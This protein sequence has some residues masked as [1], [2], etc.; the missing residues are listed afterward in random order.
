M[1]FISRGNLS[2]SQ[3]MLTRVSLSCQLQG[4]RQ[5]RTGTAADAGTTAS[6]PTRNTPE[7]RA[8]AEP[9]EF[10]RLRGSALL[11]KPI[12][13][14][15]THPT[16]ALQAN[17]EP[18]KP[19]LDSTKDASRKGHASRPTSSLRRTCDQ[20]L[21]H[22]TARKKLL[23]TPWKTPQGHNEAAEAERALT[24]DHGLHL[25]LQHN[26]HREHE[27]RHY[28]NDY[29]RKTQ[30]HSPARTYISGGNLSSGPNARKVDR[31]QDHESKESTPEPKPTRAPASGLPSTSGERCR[32][33][34]QATK[35]L[36]DAPYVD[37]TYASGTTVRSACNTS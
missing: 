18:S 7:F 28:R 27:P 2:S 16:H 3:L 17:V 34:T 31:D 15:G 36:F 33:Y 14:Q 6:R 22:R 30:T 32:A 8:S 13:I 9:Q 23:P 21:Q 20:E 35:L 25:R 12:E 4:I 11:A 29:L 24:H 5:Q 19:E 26:H 10:R 1:N 37:C